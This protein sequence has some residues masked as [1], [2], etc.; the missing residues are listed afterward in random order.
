MRKQS[1]KNF[2][3]IIIFLFFIFLPVS[4]FAQEPCE[5]KYPDDGKCKTDCE[6]GEY[7]DDTAGLCTTGKCCH[8]YAEPVNITLQVPLFGYV[9]AQNIAEY[10]M[11]IYNTALYIVVPII[12]VVLIFSGAL[13]VLSGGDKEVI[14]KAKSSIISAFIGLG[15]VLFSYVILSFFGLTELRVPQIEYIDHEEDFDM[16]RVDYNKGGVSGATNYESVGGSCFPVVTGSLKRISWNFGSPRSSKSVAGARCHAGVDIYTQSPGHVVAIADGVVKNIYRFITC[17]RGWGGPGETS[18]VLIY[19]SSLGATVNYGEID[20]AK[21]AVKKGQ[22]VT[23]GQFL[24]VASHCGMLHFELYQGQVSSSKAWYPPTPI[25]QANECKMKFTPPA[26]I[27]DP[28]N[29][30]KELQGK[31]CGKN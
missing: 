5:T 23:A 11:T 9:K 26:P 1:K 18:A 24:G 25:S 12:I 7:H 13:W 30:I 28:S 17:S 2:I 31:M 15:I 19:H 14:S 4:L 20:T 3:I 8:K 6:A 22:N 10:I 21:V 29:T 16:E 27:M